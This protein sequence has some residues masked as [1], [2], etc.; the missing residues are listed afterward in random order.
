MAR[1]LGAE[2]HGSQRGFLISLLADIGRDT[3][4]ALVSTSHSKLGFHPGQVPEA[5]I[6]FPRW[7]KLFFV[8]L[9]L[10]LVA[11]L[12]NEGSSGRGRWEGQGMPAL[13]RGCRW[14]WG[15]AL[16]SSAWC[17]V[18]PWRLSLFWRLTPPSPPSVA[19]SPPPLPSLAIWARLA[20][21]VHQVHNLPLTSGY[22]LAQNF[23]WLS[24]SQSKTSHT[25]GG[26]RF[27]FKRDHSPSSIQ[28]QRLDH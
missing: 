23:P 25:G 22:N 13:E 17:S 6:A 15:C 26:L 16:R 3:A 28:S 24:I 21:F 18:W 12:L 1:G 11:G 10:V 20:L 2:P 19:L 9:Q 27:V 8:C 7:K 14:G 5:R 4:D